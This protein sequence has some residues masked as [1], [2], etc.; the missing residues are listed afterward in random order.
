M[1]AL[2]ISEQCQN[3][4]SVTLHPEQLQE[5]YPIQNVTFI[6][7]NSLCQYVACSQLVFLPH[8]E[9]EYMI[10]PNDRAILW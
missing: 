9:I 8:P 7:S 10:G 1:P 2:Q 6:V 3:T 5:V 4:I